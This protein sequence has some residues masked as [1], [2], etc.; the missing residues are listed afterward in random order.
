MNTQF[1]LLFFEMTER[2]DYEKYGKN[3]VTQDPDSR[4]SKVTFSRIYFAL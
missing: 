1:V 2:F 4:R 3:S